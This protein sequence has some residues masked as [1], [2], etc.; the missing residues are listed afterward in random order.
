MLEIVVEIAALI[1]RAI[2]NIVAGFFFKQIWRRVRR[3]HHWNITLTF[4]KE[5]LWPFRRK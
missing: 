5:K 3:S 4:F 2:L 1:G